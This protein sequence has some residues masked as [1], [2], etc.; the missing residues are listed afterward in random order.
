MDL[1]WALLIETIEGESMGRRIGDVDK[2]GEV[3]HGI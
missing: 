3:E 2:E 1:E